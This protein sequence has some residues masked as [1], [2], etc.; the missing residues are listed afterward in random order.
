MGEL[1]TTAVNWLSLLVATLP[2]SYPFGAGMVAAVNPCGFAMLPAYLALYLGI[3]D[4]EAVGR[5]TVRRFG[6]ALAVAGAVSAG[7][8]VLFLVAGSLI[9][10]FGNALLGAAP[11]LGIFIGLGLVVIGVLMLAG[12]TVSTDVFERLAD[13]VSRP[14]ERTWRG[15]FLFGL[16]YGLASL[17][18]TLPIFMVVVGSALTGDDLRT[19]ISSFVSYGLGMAVVIVAIT[20][21]LSFLKY[22][23]I[24]TFRRVIPYVQTISAGLLIFA[25]GWI[26]LYWWPSVV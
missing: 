21:T 16:A 25:G 4:Q 10:A 5:S 8:V 11:W 19:G 17:S 18:C 7:F 6:N 15:F 12:R 24:D 1:Q 3:N 14:G 2:V 9:S 23:L 20:V 26:V 13:R 22:G